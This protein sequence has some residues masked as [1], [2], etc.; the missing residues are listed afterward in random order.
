MNMDELD[1]KNPVQKIRVH[2]RVSVVERLEN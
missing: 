2:L 1:K